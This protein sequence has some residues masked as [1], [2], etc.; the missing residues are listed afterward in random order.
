MSFFPQKLLFPPKNNE[1]EIT[2][3]GPGYGESIVLHVPGIGWGIVDSCVVKM[4]G[5]STVP[6]LAYLLDILSTPF[7]KLAFVLVTH[8]HEDH[9]RGLEQILNKYP[10][11]VERVCWYDSDGIRELKIY[12]TQQRVGGNYI[13]PGLVNVFKAMDE[14]VN[15]G[16]QLRRLGEMSLVLNSRNIAIHGY[17][18]TDICL[19]ALSPSAVSI[20]KYVEMLFN[21]FPQKGKPIFP[22]D[23]EAHNLISVALLLKLGD[24]QVILGSDVES[25]LQD[26]TG[27]Q[28]IISNKDCPELWANFVKVSHHG[29]ENGFNSVAWEKHCSRKLKPIAITTPFY[30]GNVILPQKG[31]TEKLK[32]VSYKFGLTSSIKLEKNLHRYYSRDVVEHLTRQIRSIRVIKPP[33]RIGFIRVRFL[34]N[35]QITECHAEPP[36]NW[37]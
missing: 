32:E 24:L 19:I 21:A 9:Y 14:A 6:P 12:L 2:T 27:W 5:T 30:K 17:G 22:L 20:K 34:L 18:T 29:S 37:Y 31:D 3:F 4:G 28:G 11:G 8:P 26:N 15:S 1:V 25:G 7:P 35:G 36:A 23:D 16:A 33:E 13:L 10:G